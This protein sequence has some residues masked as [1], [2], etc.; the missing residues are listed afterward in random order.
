MTDIDAYVAGLI[1]GE[2]CIYLQDS[3]RKGQGRRAFCLVVEVGMASKAR[4][5]LEFLQ[6]TYGGTICKSRDATERWDAAYAWSVHGRSA[7]AMLRRLSPYLRLKEEQARLVLRAEEIR[8]SLIPEN[9][10][11]ARWTAEA[12]TRCLTIRKRIQELNRKGPSVDPEYRKPPFKGATLIALRVADQWVT[13]QADLLSD[14][15]W[16]PWSGPWPRSAFTWHGGLWTLSSS[17]SRSDAVES[18]LSDAL[19]PM[20]EGLSKYCLSPKAAQGILRRAKRR[21]RT[22]PAPLAAALEA[23]AQPTSTDTATTSSTA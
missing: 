22:L 2:G 4:P 9:G 13:P 5:V 7:A 11:N 17:E 21:G 15:G 6:K 14:L 10:T 20:H 23:V 18:S 12:S 16:A 8:L 1:D 19:E 3:T